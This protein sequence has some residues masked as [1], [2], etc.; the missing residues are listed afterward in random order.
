[1][2]RTFTTLI[3]TI[4]AKAAVAQSSIHLQLTDTRTSKPL[5]F[6]TISEGKNWLATTDS[7][8]HA[9]VSLAAGAHRITLSL[10]G[11]NKLDTTI[12]A[13]LSS[14]IQISLA[15]AETALEEVTVISSTRNNQAIENS[16]L[17]VEVLGSE[18][19]GEEA[20]IKP[21]NIA[22][23]LGDVSG[24][25]IQQSSATS[26]N[27]NVRIQGLDGRY[28][29]I[30]R[31][32]MP[33]YDGFSGG[34][35]ILTVPPL[36]LKQIELIKGSASTLFG[37][38]AIGGLINLISRR[39]TTKQELDAL[40]NYT[41]LK[42]FN[43]NIYAA[44]RGRKTGY[45]LFTGYNN[46]KAV[47]V[48]KDGF[49]DVPNASSFI[50]HPRL[51]YYPTDKTIIYAGYSG[52]FDTRKGGDIQVLNNNA[53]TTHQYYDGNTSQR[54]TAEYCAEQ[55]LKG[56]AK[57][58]IKGNISTFSKDNTNRTYA[59]SGR[60]VSYY[61]EASVYIPVKKSDV[62]SGINMTGDKYTTTSPDNASYQSLTNS[63]IGAFSQLNWHVHD[64]TTIEGGLRIDHHNRYGMFVLPRIAAFHRINENWGMRAGFGMG[65]KTPNPLSQ[66]NIELTPL[67]VLPLQQ[68]IKAEHSYGSNAEVNYKTKIGEHGTLF[69]NEALFLTS[70]TNP[71]VFYMNTAGKIGLVN[72]SP[73]TISTGSDSYVK[74]LLH[75]WEFYLGYTYTDARNRYLS[76]NNFVP[77]TPKHRAAFVVVKEIEEDWRIGLEGSLTGRQYRYDGSATPA[78]FFMAAMIQRNIGKHLA[79]VL[80][81]ENLFDYRMSKVES[82]YTGSSTFPTFKPLWAPIDGRVINCSVRWK[83]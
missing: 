36:D 81:A 12:S 2:K 69:I 71:T 79:V 6:A 31:D 24:V 18:E 22:S 53:D 17:K 42:E 78:W 73:G 9:T 43:A 63:T 26:G 60:Q 41:S 16:P 76:G 74:M 37:G 7:S 45:T 35:G 64:N 80:N 46:Q 8:G 21:G 59:Y 1:M 67:D 5:E 4:A 10:T 51:Y 72:A 19:L 68:G 52:T 77:L 25:Q 49:S 11:Y 82:L 14:A 20:G 27:S 15:S 50:V 54:H 40:I 56:G 23:I 33:L 55:F 48:N 32:G 57:L 62:V 70:L 66:Q 30:L 47:D 75:S 29:Q 13:P 65:Y 83:L 34:F 28:T 38:G 58:T 39:P 3:L 61:N 44:K